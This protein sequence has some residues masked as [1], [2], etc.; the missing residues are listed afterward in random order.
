M[1]WRRRCA[2]GEQAGVVGE[3]SEDGLDLLTPVEKDLFQPRPHKEGVGEIAQ[4]PKRDRIMDEIGHL[5][6]PLYFPK[7]MLMMPQAVRALALL[8]DEVM[9]LFDL[10]DLREPARAEPGQWP[11]FIFEELS[12]ID[13]IPPRRRKDH[14]LHA[15][16]GYPGQI[17]GVHE[18]GPHFLQGSGDELYPMYD[19]NG[20][21]QSYVNRR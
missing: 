20:H 17:S 1:P 6:A 9:P 15:G 14:K 3:W 7:M 18:K 10:R 12:G 4:R 21:G 16:R 13:A 19:L 2:H 11:E 8:V 5:D